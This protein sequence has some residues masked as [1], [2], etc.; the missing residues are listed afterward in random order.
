MGAIY[1]YE[2]AREQGHRRDLFAN[3][4]MEI[5]W[6]FASLP[7]PVCLPKYSPTSGGIRFNGCRMHMRV[8]AASLRI[9]HKLEDVGQHT[10]FFFFFFC[11]RGRPVVSRH[12]QRKLSVPEELENYRIGA[13]TGLSSY[14]VPRYAEFPSLTL[15][16]ALPCVS[17]WSQ[18]RNSGLIIIGHRYRTRDPA[19]GKQNPRLDL[20]L[21]VSCSEARP[22]LPKARAAFAHQGV[23]CI[24]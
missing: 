23:A 20:H 22:L 2:W 9:T 19:P 16:G 13:N 6:C 8:F 5:F 7:D 15:P 10:F 17:D 3:A 4:I 24:A 14:I 21:T 1:E 12:V 18:Q 11:R